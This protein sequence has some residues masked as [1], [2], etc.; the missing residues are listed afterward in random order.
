MKSLSLGFYC[1]IVYNALPWVILTI[2]GV[3]SEYFI[4]DR[5][6]NLPLI[7]QLFI[8][9]FN[10][11]SA[12]IM[13]RTVANYVGDNRGSWPKLLMTL[14]SAVIFFNNQTLVSL[15]LCLALGAIVSLYQ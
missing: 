6:M 15:L 12:G 3:L 9:G 13:V 14:V 1:F 8:M 7:L 2:L 5:I 4:T 11:A 10:A